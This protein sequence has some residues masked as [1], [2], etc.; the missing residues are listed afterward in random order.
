MTA[1]RPADLSKDAPSYR[2]LYRAG[3]FAQR[4][5]IDGNE[6]RK[7]AKARGIHLP[8]FP[9]RQV[10]EPLD[11][12]GAFSPLAF[13]QTNS[14]GVQTWLRPDPD[15]YL[16]REAHAFAPW[17]DRAWQPPWRDGH[18]IVA[19]CYSPWQLLYLRDAVDELSV[20]VDARVLLDQHSLER[21]REG[22]ELQ[23]RGRLARWRKLDDDWRSL[24]K[25]LVA[26]QS[27]FLPYRTGKT[28]LLHD[29]DG[30]NE[31]IDPT[32]I[33]RRDF[34]PKAILHAFHLELDELAHLHF[35]IAEDGRRLDPTPSWYEL[36]DAAPR[37]RTDLLRNDALLARDFYDA[38]FLL[39]GLY[40]LATDE[41][42]PEP[43]QLEPEPTV[44][45]W[46]RRHL[47]RPGGER[48]RSR[49]DVKHV[50]IREGVYPHLVHC[51]VEGV[52]EDIIFG[53]LLPFLGFNE[54]AGFTVTNIHG[55]DNAKRY[56]TLFN[57]AT[58]YAARTVLIADKEGDIE[59]T[60]KRLRS[61]GLFTD[62]SDVLLWELDGQ[63][64]SFEEVNFTMDELLDGI[65]S[66]GARRE[67]DAHLSL[68]IDQANASFN[69]AVEAAKVE[70]KPRP[71][72]AGLVL[73]LA[74]SPEYG[75]ISV[76]K[77]EL[78]RELAETLK[79]AI[80]EAGHLAA[81]G[82]TRPLLRGLWRWIA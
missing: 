32:E 76:S 1:M 40:Y 17:E 72:I 63:P 56:E 58:Q 35:S 66:A 52:T 78:A 33:A 59:R 14:S 46:E 48:S 62:E 36:L 31:R 57:A 39:R 81:A 18:P 24:I 82:Q 19:E 50:L 5:F 69:E 75:A 3:S 68:T 22:L 42:L 12:A 29:A 49:M 10:L 37:E 15:L 74:A 64:S 27:R 55:V 77:Q 8:L 23:A 16:W 38:A 67:P 54:K 79:E 28:I 60:L 73:K 7:Q 2:E 61:A 9:Q 34:D 44:E 45:A 51:F 80:R 6:L 21:D 43:D 30:S 41:W 70:G 25:L 26:L 20:P 11:Q 53:R 13:C 47:P 71:A 65:R 4:A